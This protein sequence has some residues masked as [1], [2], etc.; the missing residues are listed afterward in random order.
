MLTPCDVQNES[1]NIIACS[2]VNKNFKAANLEQNGITDEPL[3][4]R[5]ALQYVVVPGLNY[6][7]ITHVTPGQT[8]DIMV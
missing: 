4:T 6:S 8:M 2:S 7:W 5:F 3:W 1:T